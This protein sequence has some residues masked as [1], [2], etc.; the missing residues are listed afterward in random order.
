M[1][2]DKTLALLGAA[3]YM[4]QRFEFGLYGLAAHYSH[5]PAAK[6]DKQFRDLDPEKFLRGDLSDL[7]ATLGQISYTFGNQFHLAGDFLDEFLEKRNIIVHR[8]WR[9]NNDRASEAP[10]ADPDEYL[11]EFITE[12]EHWI[13]VLRGIYSLVTEGAAKKEG[14]ESEY[15]RS[16]Q[17]DECV[18]IFEEFVGIQNLRQL[19]SHT[20]ASA[21]DA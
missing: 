15:V 12:S 9:F 8:F 7:R 10:F 17:D 20:T 2:T 11:Q 13:K 14:R 16:E 21:D 5:I 1:I 6:K 19:V 4:V 3:I 18:R